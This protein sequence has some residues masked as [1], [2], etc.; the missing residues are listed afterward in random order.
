MQQFSLTESISHVYKLAVAEFNVCIQS[1]PSECNRV[2]FWQMEHMWSMYEETSDEQIIF[3]V[4]ITR[5]IVHR[6]SSPCLLSQS[7]NVPDHLNSITIVFLLQSL[8]L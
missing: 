7:Q 3:I 6:V 2:Q 5:P 1:T 8:S 4:L